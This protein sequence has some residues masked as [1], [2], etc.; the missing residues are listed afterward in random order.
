MSNVDWSPYFMNDHWKMITKLA[1]SWCRC[2]PHTCCLIQ[3]SDICKR[4]VQPSSSFADIT[5]LKSAP[6][7]WCA[8]VSSSRFDLHWLALA[9][10]PEDRVWLWHKVIPRSS[11]VS[12]SDYIPISSQ[13]VLSNKGKESPIN[14]FLKIHKKFEALPPCS[15]CG[16]VRAP[17]LWPG[18]RV[19][20]G[21]GLPAPGPHG[22]R[23]CELS[24]LAAPGDGWQNGETEIICLS[25]IHTLITF[26]VTRHK[27]IIWHEKKWVSPP[28]T[29]KEVN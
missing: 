25:Y 10:T 24:S 12:L 6:K 28:K 15:T 21:I 22:A 13:T 7:R 17:S 26:I 16:T 14:T 18:G 9:V 29:E 19:Y 23:R 5:L 27:I 2:H 4:G 8:L 20:C 3:I 1:Y 11:S